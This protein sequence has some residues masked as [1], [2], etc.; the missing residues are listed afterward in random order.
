MQGKTHMAAAATISLGIITYKTQDFGMLQSGVL[1]VSTIAG[2]LLPDIDIKNS[3]VSHKHKF[4]SFFIRLFIEHRGTHSVIFMALLS[5]PLFLL[6]MILPSGIRPYGITFG[7]EILLGYASHIILDMLTP[8][9]S[10]VLNPISK[11]SVSLLRIKTG[12]VIEFM[13]RMAMYILVIYMGWMMVS[14]IISDVLER[15]PFLGD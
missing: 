3:K 6:T 4:L 8:K 1:I 14:P 5:I 12:G 13:I 11:Y 2:S 15:L 10:P 9:G 7:F